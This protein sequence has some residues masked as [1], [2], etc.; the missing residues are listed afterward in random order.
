METTVNK[1]LA[2]SRRRERDGDWI[3]TLII[4]LAT[5]WTVAVVVGFFVIV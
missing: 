1:P 2:Q 5:G 4:G 3:A